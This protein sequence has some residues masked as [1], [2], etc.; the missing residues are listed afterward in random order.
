MARDKEVKPFRWQL[1]LN[2]HVLALFEIQYSLFSLWVSN[3]PAHTNFVKTTI[4]SHVTA[5][6]WRGRFSAGLLVCGIQLTRIL[7]TH[8]G[9][10]CSTRN[11]SM[12][13]EP[14]FRQNCT[15]TYAFTAIA[16]TSVSVWSRSGVKLKTGSRR[17]VINH[18]NICFRREVFVVLWSQ[19]YMA[20]IILK[21]R[22]FFFF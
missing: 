13:F 4:C 16:C 3:W 7:Q 11:L 10:H 12:N 22:F 5:K 18:E 17:R 6:C 20:W 8:K 2:F 15:D 14:F 19:P 1:I 21:K 9:F